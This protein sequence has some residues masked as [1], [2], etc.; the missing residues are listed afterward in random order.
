MSGCYVKIHTFRCRILHAEISSKLMF[1]HPLIVLISLNYWMLK[2]TS[3]IIPK[4]QYT[5]PAK[6]TYWAGTRMSLKC[7]ALCTIPERVS[8]VF[9]LWNTHRHINSRLCCQGRLCEVRAGKCASLFLN[10]QNP[11]QLFMGFQLGWGIYTNKTSWRNSITSCNVQVYWWRN[12]KALRMTTKPLSW[13]AS[14]PEASIMAPYLKEARIELIWTNLHVSRMDIFLRSQSTLVLR[15]LH[16]NHTPSP[17]AVDPD[18][19]C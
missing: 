14:C 17:P 1:S 9:F 3:W 11:R 12:N 19:A 15:W 7:A 16:R 13:A 10:I 5:P 18:P 8:F 6:I 2:Y 4:G